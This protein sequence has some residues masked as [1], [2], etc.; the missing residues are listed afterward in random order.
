MQSKAS[1]S[2]IYF[3]FYFVLVWVFFLRD[4]FYYIDS[5]KKL[6]FCV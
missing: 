1:E 4:G 2:F 6:L 3:K 5:V